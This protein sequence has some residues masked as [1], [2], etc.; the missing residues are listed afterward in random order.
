[1]KIA[2]TRIDAELTQVVEAAFLEAFG[3]SK[4]LAKVSRERLLDLIEAVARVTG[5]YTRQ[6]PFTLGVSHQPPPA[7]AEQETSHPAS[8]SRTD[9]LNL[10]AEMASEFWQRIL[11]SKNDD[12][13]YNMCV[14]LD[15]V[16]NVLARTPELLARS[17]ATAHAA[18]NA[19]S[20]L[21]Y[22]WP[23][24]PLAP[25]VGG[26]SLPVIVGAASIPLPRS[27]TCTTSFAVGRVSGSL[28]SSARLACSRKLCYWHAPRSLINSA[29]SKTPGMPWPPTRNGPTST[30]R[31]GPEGRSPC[32]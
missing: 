32:S 16:G 25:Q 17:L 5:P 3:E 21:P 30:V 15:T 14:V 19:R 23:L 4:V 6:R 18:S 24:D 20:G 27:L 29:P 12:P 22:G 13:I 2:L 7:E 26:K 11:T 31:S 9:H 10:E 1:M 8:D 28:R